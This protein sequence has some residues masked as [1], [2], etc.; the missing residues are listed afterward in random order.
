MA[1]Q[2]HS[3]PVAQ[4]EV[5]PDVQPEISTQEQARQAQA[6]AADALN[7]ARALGDA[8]TDLA[9]GSAPQPELAKPSLVD[10]VYAAQD[11]SNAISEPSPSNV[12]SG[13]AGAIE[14][15]N[16][17]SSLT[18]G[19]DLI[20][21]GTGQA[22]AQTLESGLALNDALHGDGAGAVVADSRP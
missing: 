13:T 17:F 2:P 16:Q 3:Q 12:A 1:A 11:V 14:L 20:D 7:G 4:T 8:W 6:L 15:V 9:G 5:Q 19:H 10:T 18:T 21:Q 22:A